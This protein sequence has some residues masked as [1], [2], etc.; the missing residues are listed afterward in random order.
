MRSPQPLPTGEVRGDLQAVK[1]SW[2]GSDWLASRP[3]QFKTP[4]AYPP[5]EK[6]KAAMVI[7]K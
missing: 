5:I 2:S 7:Q 4:A 1:G 3:F 6:G